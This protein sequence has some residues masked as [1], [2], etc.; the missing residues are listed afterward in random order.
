MVSLVSSVKQRKLA[1]NLPQHSQKVRREK[2]PT[3]SVSTVLADNYKMRA[4]PHEQRKP[5]AS[6]S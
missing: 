3:H 5:Q 6:T 1:V 4:R 2:S